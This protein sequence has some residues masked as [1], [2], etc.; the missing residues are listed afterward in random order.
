[1]NIQSYQATLYTPLFYSSAEGRTVKTSRI[2]SSTALSYALGY[3]YFGLPKKYIQRGDEITKSDYTP[4]SRLPFIVTDMTPIDVRE[5]ERTFRSTNYCS[6]RCFT[7]QDK[8]I[9]NSIDSGAHGIPRILGKS[10]S[11]SSW[12]TMRNYIGLSPGSEF[13]FTIAS[14]NKDLN[15]A[16]RFRMG[17]KK[18]GEFRAQPVEKSDEVTLNKYMLNQV[19][20]LDDS[21]LE[22]IM[23]NCRRF[24]RGNDV[25]LQH[26][27]GVPTELF[28]E[29]GEEALS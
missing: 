2:V 24:R 17:I 20:D 10:A 11:I 18:T 12:K 21:L 23:S 3:N 28:R 27:E 25:R 13:R 16:F 8:D 1:M 7:T 6:E 22:R 15:R 14:E 9:A 26:F 5:S 4:L 19:Y 29:I